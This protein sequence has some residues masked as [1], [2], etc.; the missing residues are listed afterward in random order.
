MMSCTTS[1]AWSHH[2]LSLYC[3]EHGLY[4]G[5]VLSGR[6]TSVAM[7]RSYQLSRRWIVAACIFAG[8]S[9]MNER[10]LETREP[11]CVPRA[12]RHFFIPVVHNPPGVVGHVA[13]Q[14]LISQKGRAPSHVTHGSI[15]YI[16]APELPS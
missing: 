7:F 9:V 1:A 11:S 2:V 16:A 15:R 13:A 8:A 10:A 4:H 12:A 5:A 3:N 6:I 14:E